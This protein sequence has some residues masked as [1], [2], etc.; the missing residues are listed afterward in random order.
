MNKL[1]VLLVGALL[2]LLTLPLSIQAQSRVDEDVEMTTFANLDLGV[3][4]I[5]PVG[6]NQ[7]QPGIFLRQRDPLDLT[8]LVQLSVP[9]VRA[10]EVFELVQEQLNLPQLDDPDTTLETDAL[11]WDV[12]TLSTESNNQT[13][14]VDVGLA[15]DESRVYMVILRV[16]ERFYANYHEKVFTPIVQALQPFNL[17]L[18]ELYTAPDE[19]YSIP[20]PES[21]TVTESE[22]YVTLNSPNNEVD[23][24]LLTVSTDDP[25]T[26]IAEA[27][28]R[29]NP[30]YPQVYTAADTFSTTDPQA[31]NG[32]DRVFGISYESP[33]VDIVTQAL[34]YVYQ[35]TSYVII[36]DTDVP[37]AQTYS[38][39][40]SLLV[41]QFDISAIPDPA[42]ATPEATAEATLDPADS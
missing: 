18:L 37:A 4:G 38:P 42:E 34:A 30:D 25:E 13:L 10:D 2:M 8:T 6:W 9:E 39:E 12:Y 19:S 36:I 40:L 22:E 33:V 41:E 7:V 5:R 16:N 14:T 27:W 20:L 17:G 11:T 26:A 23:M 32:A 35:G 31:I 24:H 3:R 28:Q 15:E 1:R 29:I 21:W